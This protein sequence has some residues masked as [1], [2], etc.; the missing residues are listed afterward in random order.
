MFKGLMFSI[1]VFFFWVRGVSFR[2]LVYISIDDEFALFDIGGGV[3]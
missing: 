2:F 3:I 1:Y